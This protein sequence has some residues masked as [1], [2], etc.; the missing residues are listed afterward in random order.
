MIVI[1]NRKKYLFDYSITKKLSAEGRLQ[2]QFSEAE[3]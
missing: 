1:F 2:M 3:E